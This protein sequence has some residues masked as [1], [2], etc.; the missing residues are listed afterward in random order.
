MPYEELLKWVE[1][2]KIRP[3]GWREDH[4]AYLYLR[5]QGVTASAE[6]IFPSLKQIKDSENSEKL[7]DQVI[8]K[9]K[10]LQRMI[11]AKKGDKVDWLTKKRS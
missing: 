6:S 11:E 10:F 9:G 1:F 3:I 4:R 5:T 8:P 7:P 2:F